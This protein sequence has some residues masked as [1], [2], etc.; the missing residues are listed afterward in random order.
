MKALPTIKQLTH[1]I[2]LYEQQHFTKAAKAC[3]ITQSALSA[4]IQELEYLLDVCLIDR[5][6]RKVSFTAAGVE[7]VKIAQKIL[8][9]EYELLDLAQMLSAPLSGVVRLGVIPTLAPWLMPMVLSHIYQAYPDINIRI[10]EL[11]TSKILTALEAGHLDVALIALPWDITGFEA[12]IVAKEDM[13]IACGKEH[14]WAKKQTLSLEEIENEQI[15]LLED[16][17][18]LRKHALEVCRYQGRKV[19]ED[20]QASSVATMLQMVALRPSATLLPRMATK[21]GALLTSKLH[22]IELEEYLPLREIALVWREGSA[23]KSDWE[24]LSKPCA[25]AAQEILSKK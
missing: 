21:S 15:I 14:V 17:H 22:F 11:P 4:S 12:K 16:D 7:I 25:F 1:L 2:A 5:A 24:L 8:N 23:K 10:K 9:L 3:F 19:N 13:V 18:C 20:F 6:G